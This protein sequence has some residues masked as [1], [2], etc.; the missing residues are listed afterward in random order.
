GEKQRVALARAIL[1][2]S[3]IFFFDEA[4]S[5]LDTQTERAIMSNVREILSQKQC[6]AVFIAHR[7]RTVADADI[8]F[9]LKDGELVEQGRHEELMVLGGVYKEMWDIQEGSHI[10]A[11]ARTD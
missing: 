2:D 10:H 6:T 3:P 8:I 4:T 9:V 11:D 7:L 5:A 1:K